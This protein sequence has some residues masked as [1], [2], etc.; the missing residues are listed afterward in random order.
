MSLHSPSVHNETQPGFHPGRFWLFIA[1]VVMALIGVS[2]AA[3]RLLNNPTRLPD[4]PVLTQIDHDLVASE[5]DG[6]EIHL[7]ALHGKVTVFAYLYTVCPHGCAAI[8][9]QFQK[10][11][12]EFG[13]RPDF[14]I[15]SVAIEPE[16]DTAAQ[17]SSYAQAVGVNV[18]DPWWFITGQRQQLWDFMT[19]DLGMEPAR[20]IPPDERVN[21]DDHYEHDLRIVLVDRRGRVRRYYSVFHP[22][23]E[24]ASLMMEKLPQDV[25]T[26]LDNPEL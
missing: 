16:R 18:G 21:E 5:R 25:R 26:L 2:L 14:H 7:S 22:Q 24:V 11:N 6:R 4:L 9:A 12:R 1:G 20:E 8:T 3:S 15:V 23:P 19:K 17:L 10:L 13:H